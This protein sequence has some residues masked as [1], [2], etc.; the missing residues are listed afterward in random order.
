MHVWL[1]IP[2]YA[3]MKRLWHWF[4]IAV[5]AYGNVAFSQDASVPGRSETRRLSS[6]SETGTAGYRSAAANA[7]A[8]KISS[9]F[10]SSVECHADF[11]ADNT[12][13]T[14][15]TKALNKCFAAGGKVRLKAGI[16]KISSYLLVPANTFVT[17]DGPTATIIRLSANVPLHVPWGSQDQ[18]QIMLINGDNAGVFNLQIDADGFKGCGIGVWYFANNFIGGNDIRNCGSSAQGI[19]QSGSSY[20]YVYNNHI[21]NTMHGM[22]IWQVTHGQYSD[23][24]I[25][26]AAEGGFFEADSEDLI[27]YGNSISNCGDVGLDAEGGVDVILIGN[28]VRN[29]KFGELSYFGNGTGSGRIPRNIV[30]VNNV[31]YR[32]PVYLAGAAQTSEPTSTE[33]GGIMLASSTDGETGIVFSNNAVHATGRTA[34]WANDQGAGV[35]TGFEIVH[36]ELTSDDRLFTFQR[37]SGAVIRDNHLHGLSGAEIHEGEWKN[38]DGGAFVNNTFDYDVTKS[39]GYALRYYTD[40]AIATSPMIAGNVCHNCGVFAFEH[41]PYNSGVPAIVHDNAFSDTWQANGGVHATSNGYPLYRGQRLLISFS[42]VKTAS[43][44]LS[45]LTALG[46]SLTRARMTLRVSSTGAPGNTYDLTRP[47]GAVIISHSGSGAGPGVGASTTRY[48]SFSGEVIRLNGI[49]AQTV[50]GYLTLDLTSSQ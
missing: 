21:F 50:T 23:N 36:N 16:Y 9:R 17:G 6:S 14:D 35:R 34:L 24:V 19:L 48:A 43:L 47:A 20:Q 1:A 4:A 2:I 28:T 5:L 29:A 18:H 27:V 42:G 31:A 8:K 33:A 41:D 12:G 46:G 45:T 37:A 40:V 44:D 26:T 49:T 13:T 32:T 10:R 25:D 3:A 15:A 11:A 7:I 30:F 38:P 39:K 22:Q